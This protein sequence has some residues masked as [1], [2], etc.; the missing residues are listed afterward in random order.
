MRDN[1]VPN[2]TV[3][4]DYSFLNGFFIPRYLLWADNDYI[5]GARVFE[6]KKQQTVEQKL[7]NLLSLR[8]DE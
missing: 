1:D 6:R 3:Q 2:A 4:N 8:I 5:L 7:G